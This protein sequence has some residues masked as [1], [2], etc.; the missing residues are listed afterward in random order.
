MTIPKQRKKLSK[1]F[2]PQTLIVQNIGARGEGISNKFTE[3]NFIEKE[4]NFFIPFALPAEKI[5]VKPYYISSEGIRANIIEVIE[6]SSERI[7]AKCKHFFK[8]GG[9]I[10]Q[11]VSYTHLRAHET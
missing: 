4:Y 6:P 10:L 5:I 11:P 7:E 2:N 8:C 9:C 3:M 1:N